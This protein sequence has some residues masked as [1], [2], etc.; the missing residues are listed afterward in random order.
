MREVAPSE[1]SGALGVQIAGVTDVG[2]V[3]R[4]NEDAIDWDRQLGLVMVADG[5]GGSQ[6]GDI[7]SRTALQSIKDDLRR[8]VAERRRQGALPLSREVQGALVAE[9]V[10]RANQ[11]VRRSAA[12][13]NRLLGMGT[14]L[15][16]A[17][18]G[19]DFVTCA[20][21]GDSRLYRLRGETMLRLTD[22]HSMVQELVHRGQMNEREA[23]QSRHRNVIT[24]ALGISTDVLVDVEHHAAEPGDL[25][26]LCS[27]GLTNMLPE[28][29]IAAA[30]VMHANDL[31]AAAHHAVGLANARGGR[32]NVS[33]VLLRILP[34]S[35]G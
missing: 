7:A 26:M 9:L 25:F 15:V 3:R 21:V 28:A 18:V 30:L 24:R 31:Q 1:R 35:H 16:M 20:H 13:D 22:D 2:R 11:G 33:V 27:D 5:M 12:R 23:A 6:G 10:R 32:D 14:T 17:L 19:P 29:E 8:A 4:R 34:P